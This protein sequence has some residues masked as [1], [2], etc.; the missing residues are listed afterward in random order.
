M[1]RWVLFIIIGLVVLAACGEPT[2]PT[3]GPLKI[4]GGSPNIG[5]LTLSA[6]TNCA[7]RGETIMF[8]L[9]VVNPADYPLQFTNPPFFDMTI[10]KT[11]G[12]Q[13][14]WSDTDQY[15]SAINPVMAPREVRE[16]HWEWVS[17]MEGWLSIEVMTAALPPGDTTPNINQASLYFG[18]T[19][20]SWEQGGV[21]GPIDC[22]E[23]KR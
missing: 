15:P 2:P 9:R 23:L 19:Y 12:V 20:M 14:R 8:T 13:I 5:E 16:Y 6:T 17:N 7:L 1:K 10:V 18:V 22:V 11:K 21:G 3:I 4:H